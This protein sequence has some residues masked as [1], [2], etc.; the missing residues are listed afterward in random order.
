M[1]AEMLTETPHVVS[2]AEAQKLEAE[3]EARIHG[4][5]GGGIGS[6]SGIGSGIG[7]GNGNAGKKAA[8][9]GMAKVAANVLRQSSQSG[10]G[11]TT[12]STST[13]APTK[14]SASEISGG[15]GEG[16]EIGGGADKKIPRAEDENAMG[17]LERFKRSQAQGE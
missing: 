2:D 15:T 16:G 8:V 1:A 6:G 3:K 7:S 5:T 11:T 4:R 14:R 13:S 17:A 10:T 12:T 9:A